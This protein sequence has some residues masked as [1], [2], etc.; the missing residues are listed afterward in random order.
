MW[1][2]SAASFRD[3]DQRVGEREGVYFV[4]PTAEVENEVVFRKS[5]KVIFSHANRIAHFGD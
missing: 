4:R 2:I 3:G 1:I 5:A